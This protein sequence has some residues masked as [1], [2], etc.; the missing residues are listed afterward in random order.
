MSDED[1]AYARK[2]RSRSG[3]DRAIDGGAV[4]AG[5]C[6]GVFAT[7]VSI[8]GPLSGAA[9]LSVTALCLVCGGLAAGYLTRPTAS[10][11]LQGALVV[12]STA[13]LMAAVSMSMTYGLGS[14]RRVP[15]VLAY[16]TL[17]PPAFA[18]LGTLAVC[19]GALS[20]TLGVGLRG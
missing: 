17:A 10:G 4:A 2:P 1:P 14:P 6:F 7:F 12:C 18:A 19:L 11:A 13:G 3:A 5:L 15:L 20:G 9:R 16:E 8:V